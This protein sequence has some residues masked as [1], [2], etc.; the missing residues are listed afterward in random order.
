MFTYRSVNSLALIYL[1]KLFLNCS[2]TRELVLRSSDTDLKIPLLKSIN[3]QKAFMERSR[4]A[5]NTG[6]FPESL[7]R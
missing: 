3:D 6:S 4:N 7:Q 1:R 5:S 2:D